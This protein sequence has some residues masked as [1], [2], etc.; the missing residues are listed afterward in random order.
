MIRHQSDIL[1]EWLAILIGIHSKMVMFLSIVVQR[2]SLVLG[3]LGVIVAV[4]GEVIEELVT[5]EATRAEEV[6]VEVIA[7]VEIG[8]VDR[9]EEDHGMIGVIRI[10]Y[11]TSRSVHYK[12]FRWVVI[13]GVKEFG[14]EKLW[15]Y[16]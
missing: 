1:Q 13:C 11:G 6:M 7:I 12:A 10:G 8:V 5:G 2:F 15:M 16:D 9:I 14:A 4:Q 3:P